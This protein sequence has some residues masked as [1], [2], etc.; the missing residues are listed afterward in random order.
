M[1]LKRVPDSRV[2]IGVCLLVGGFLVLPVGAG[3][4]SAS[5]HWAFRAVEA[6]TVP[7]EAGSWSANPVDRFI[8]RKI[9]EKQLRPTGDASRAVLVRRLYFDLLGLPPTPEEVQAFVED[10]SEDAY[11]RL[12]D[13]LLASTHYGERWGRYWLDV[14]RYADTAG[15]NADYPIPEMFRYRDYVID[16]FNRDKPFDRFLREQIAGD[17]M[18][19][20]APADAQWDLR[21]ATGFIALSRRFGTEPFQ[22]PHLEIEDTIDT[23]GRAMLAMTL[24]CARCH[25]H[26]F[27][28]ITNRDYYALYGFFASTQYPFS[29]SEAKKKRLHLVP[30]K[31]SRQEYDQI[32]KGY[33][34]QVKVLTDESNRLGSPTLEPMRGQVDALRSQINMAKRDGKP[35]SEIDA[36]Q[37]EYDAIYKVLQARVDEVKTRLGDLHDEYAYLMEISAYAVSEGKPTDVRL[38]LQG[39]PKQLGEVIPRNAP[40]VLLASGDLKI[41][42]GSSG[43]LQ[44]AEWVA[45]AENPLTARVMVNRIWK[46]HFGQGLVETVSN[47]GITG[48]SPSHPELLDWLAGKFVESGWSIKQLHRLLLMSRTYRLSSEVVAANQAIDP[49]NVY[50]WH[51]RR[52]QLDA[53][54]IRDAMLAVSGD[55]DLTVAGAHPFAP[56][57]EWDYSQ[58]K[59]FVE[60]YP[61]SKRSVYL[62]TQRIQRHPYLSIFDGADTNQ[63][64]GER[65]ESILPQQALFLMNH[66]F[67]KERAEGLSRRLRTNSDEQQR[68]RTAYQLAWGRPPGAAELEQANHYITRY[69][70]QLL[71]AGAQPG[72]VDVEA[73]TSFARLMLTANEFLYID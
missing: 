54:A 71:S 31:H 64:T 47:F 13:R 11:A 50:C 41:P 20:T 59:P 49:G 37:K 46:H 16:S 10:R 19:E 29:G 27:D 38:Q 44:L 4:T 68:I 52:R 12:V 67:V 30:L 3:S 21:V 6:V 14:A 17:I 7:E 56:L 8:L 35:Q 43:R 26:K 69:R 70:S 53:E 18:A 57:R 48:A 24:K 66:S 58:H 22:F 15:D 42:A 32:T 9:H 51:Y 61:T 62:M 36:L 23:M 33:N 40:V 34:E 60:V 72:E 2:V 39:D 65:A 5:Q 25:D 1:L 63:S 45:A 73:W 55:L 28:P